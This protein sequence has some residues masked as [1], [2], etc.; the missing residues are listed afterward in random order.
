M[1]SGYLDQV[2]AI[3]QKVQNEDAPVLSQAAEWIFETIQ[4]GHCV[5][6][7]GCTHAGILAQEAFYRTGGLVVINPVFVPGTLVSDKP[8]TLTSAVE[9]LTGYGSIVVEQA[10]IGAGDLLILHSVSGRNC[11][12]V[13]MAATAKARNARIICITSMDYTT[14]VQSRHPSG[15]KLYELCD[16]VID[17]HCPYGDALIPLQ[18]AELHVGPGSTAIGVAIWNEIVC[19]TAKLFECHGMIPPVFSS[20]NVDGGENKNLELYRQYQHSIRYEMV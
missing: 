16:L 11:M 1:A 20:A 13:D 14:H 8:I 12:P 2:I 15:K 3:L 19:L 4:Q 10:G 7:Y 18:N 5:Y 6:I 9:R 17:N